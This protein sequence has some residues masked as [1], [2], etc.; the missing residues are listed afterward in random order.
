VEYAIQ[1]IDNAGAAVGILAKDGV[2]IAAEKK[3][4]SRLL[5]G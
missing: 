4:T 1:A 3:V 5:V 2:I